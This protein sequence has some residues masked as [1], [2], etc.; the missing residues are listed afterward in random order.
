MAA[1]DGVGGL[2]YGGWAPINSEFEDPFV[3]PM[4]YGPTKRPVEQ[5]LDFSLYE[6]QQH[7]INEGWAQEPL[8]GW[9]NVPIIER[10]QSVVDL[11]PLQLSPRDIALGGIVLSLLVTAALGE[12]KFLI[13]YFGMIF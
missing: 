4:D 5:N 6:Q 7:S 3:T 10:Q 11:F 12:M 2:V 8:S 13:I 1:K 9:P